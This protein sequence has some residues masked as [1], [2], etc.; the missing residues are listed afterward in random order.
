MPLEMVTSTLVL[1]GWMT[2][3]A[4]WWEH[5]ILLQDL[6]IYDLIDELTAKEISHR[7][8]PTNAQS[9][10]PSIIPSAK[11]YTAPTLRPSKLPTMAFTTTAPTKKPSSE[12]TPSPT[13]PP[14]PNPTPEPTRKPNTG[15]YSYADSTACSKSNQ[16]ACS[17]SC[18]TS[19]LCAFSRTFP[20]P[21]R[22][23][24]LLLVLVAR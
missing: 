23:W 6:D 24:F 18:F 22:R 17:E 2:T 10:A 19:N 13:P 11:P 5:A 1:A 15:T 7:A 3:F 9:V 20:S 8:A 16:C 12:P 4:I 21:D 14:T